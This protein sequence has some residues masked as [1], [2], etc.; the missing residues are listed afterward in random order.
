MQY[1][2]QLNLNI[3]CKEWITT[4]WGGTSVKLCS[5]HVSANLQGVCWNHL[6][7][8]FL[9]SRS[10]VIFDKATKNWRNLHLSF[11]IT[12][13]QKISEANYLVL[14]SSKKWAKYLPN[15]ALA[16]RAENFHLFFGFRTKKFAFEIFWP[17]NNV[18]N[19]D[20]IK[21]LCLLRI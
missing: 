18:K 16:T 12:K 6:S 21:F 2:T 17:L 7:I 14:N 9:F 3:P 20:F 4:G 19:E 1:K 5:R 11:D 15:S 10:W 8:P 13:G